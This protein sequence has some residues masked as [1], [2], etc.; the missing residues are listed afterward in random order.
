MFCAGGKAMVGELLASVSVFKTMLDMAKGLK[1]INDDAVRNTAVIELQEKILS[2]REQQTMLAER[3][4]ELEEQ[5]A[6]FEK[7]ETEKQRYE[8]DSLPPGV[9]VYTLKEDMAAG[10]PLHH[11]CQT[12]Y[13]HAKKSVLNQSET[14]R[15]VY[16]LT[17]D[18]CGADLKVGH[19]KSPG[20]IRDGGG[21][22]MGR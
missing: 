3:I 18:E 13:Q 17:C 19:W 9:H 15:G 20:V 4:R 21:S 22:W 1:D 5:V 12:C 16:H 8:L 10:E 11:I 2:A 7:W 6:Q 14:N